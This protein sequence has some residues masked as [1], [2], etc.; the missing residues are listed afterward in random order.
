MAYFDTSNQDDLN[1]LHADARDH[2]ELSNVAS[3][4]EQEILD[5]FSTIDNG[6][7]DYWYDHNEPA[8]SGEVV[9]V[10]LAGY[11]SDPANATDAFKRA[12]KQTIADV[13][14]YILLNYEKT[15]DAIESEDRGERST[16]YIEA[17]KAGDWPEAWDRKLKKFQ[18]STFNVVWSI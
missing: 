9:R 11:D 8:G 1:L 12:F 6:Y 14:S 10:N 3:R 15:E 4:V 2:N 13:T 5:Y 18:N 17:V 7:P 16:S